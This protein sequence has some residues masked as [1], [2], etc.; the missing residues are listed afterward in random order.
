MNLAKLK[1]YA[2]KARQEFIQAVTDRAALHGLKEEAGVLIAL[3]ILEKGDGVVIAGKVFPRKVAEQRKALERRIQEHG[4]SQTMEALA[5]T[6]FNRLV[7]IRYMEVHGYLDHGYRV[8]S[9]SPHA[10][11]QARGD[12]LPELLVHAD[13]VVLP[14]LR[15]Q[16][17]IDLKIDGTKDAQLYRLL[18]IAECN[19]LHSTMP[20]I[21]PK[22]DDETELLLPD[23]L[24][25]SDS[26]VRK[27]VTAITDEDCSSVEVLGWLYQFYIA[28]KKEV[29]MARKK[30]V[31]TEDIP[32]VTQI[33]TPHWIVRYLVENSL[34]RLWLLNRPASRI[35]EIMPYYAD[36]Q[37]ETRFIKVAKPEDL[38]VIDPAVGSGHMLVYAF[39]LLYAIYIEEGYA[40]SEIPGLILANNLHG[41]DICPRAAQLAALA[42]VLK[43]REKVRRFFDTDKLIQPNVRSLR[44]IRFEDGE[45]REYVRALDLGSLFYEQMLNLLHEF[46]DAT[47]FGSLIRPCLDERALAF[48]RSAI[49]AKDLGSQ[50]FL[51]TTH[52]KVLRVLDQAERLC[53]R[54]HV[55]L[56]NPPYMGSK[57]MNPSLKA[58]TSHHYRDARSD[59]MTCFMDRC[60]AFAMN[61]GMVAMINLPSWLFLNAFDDFRVKLV[62]EVTLMSLLH[63]GRG[64]FGADFGCVAFILS[65]HAAKDGLGNY[66]RLFESQSE[67]A[68]VEEIERR[69]HERQYGSFQAVQ[70]DFLKLPGCPI[71]YWMSPAMKLAFDRFPALEDVADARIGMATGKN[72]LYVRYWHEVAISRIGFQMPTRAAAKDS[73][74]RW[75]PYAKGG[76]FRKWYGNSE[77]VVDWYNDGR[78]LQT[79]LHP[80][81]ERIWAHNFNLDQVFLPAICWTV[82][83]IAETGFRYHPEGYIY[84]AAAGLCQTKTPVDAL[85][86]LGVLNSRVAA[87]TLKLINPTVNLHPGYLGRI[88]IPNND[89]VLDDVVRECLAIAKNDWDEYETSWD[90]RESPLLRTSTKGPTLEATWD[91][92]RRQ[93]DGIVDRLANL[94]TENNRLL[95]DRYGL[96]G[97]VKPEV[98]HKHITLSCNPAHRFKRKRRRKVTGDDDEVAEPVD[99]D[100]TYSEQEQTSLFLT[101][102]IKEL[103]SYAVGC[104]M[105]RYGLDRPGVILAN[106]G[107]S[108]AEYVGKVERSLELLTFRPDEDGIVPVLDVERFEDDIVVR[109]REFMK[110]AFGPHS[111]D[112]NVRFV[113]HALGKD[114][115]RYFFSGFYKDHRQTY[116]NRPLYWMFTS[117]KQRAFQCLVYLHR[118]N[119][120]TLSRMRTEYVIP[121]QG[122]LASRLERIEEEK[123]KA[124]STSGRKKLQKEQDMLKSQQAELLIFDEK[125]KHAADQK[126]TL[127][128]DDGVKVNYRKFGDLL[129]DVDDVTGGSDE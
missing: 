14:G 65:T 72:A 60:R 99:E 50:L 122:Q 58:F 129:A 92:W 25:H 85:Y 83:T 86:L 97:E 96:V 26:L 40:P 104:V 54:A 101:Q 108:I 107:D 18:V 16:T 102:T 43:A 113:E 127:D 115:R 68:S 70:A 20:F 105:G 10:T 55:V 22:I 15:Q 17:V 91:T 1:V 6:W 61:S 29:V 34:G 103:L 24:L 80:S 53:R 63:I 13:H 114:L 57:A 94:E 106:A 19:A 116:S 75:F 87:N 76:E 82:V 89:S 41:E 64:M 90:F 100:N 79:T 112:A 8:L 44:D 121:L 69:F 111:L 81:G 125:L 37:A 5:Y 45:L 7:A 33:F 36:G 39:D 35:R 95:I 62:R 30:A 28:E 3:P 123:T 12:G 46:E 118:Y 31:P 110:A 49:Q 48:A 74:R 23:N 128:L 2:P 27:L 78:A 73:G 56:A 42:L 67:V 51:R 47:T 124:T 77:A 88:P 21:F 52:H 38:R 11:D 119:G 9:P 120:G 84:D 71:A 98:D 126:I 32:A 59:L 117:G 4:F 109:T 93:C 66:R